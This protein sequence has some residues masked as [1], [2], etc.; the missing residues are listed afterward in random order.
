MD[1]DY[2]FETGVLLYQWTDTVTQSFF[3]LLQT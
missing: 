2:I 1:G 3:I